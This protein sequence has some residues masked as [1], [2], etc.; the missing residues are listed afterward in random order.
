MDLTREERER[1]NDSR[2]KIQS[3]ASTLNQV[4]SGNI[5]EYAEIQ[6]CLQHAE[7]SLTSALQTPSPKR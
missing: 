1:I 4:R 3:I 2:L 5:P 7:H 6:D